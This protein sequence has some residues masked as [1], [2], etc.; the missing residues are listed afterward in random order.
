[1]FSYLHIRS[2]IY[3]FDLT[4]PIS[5]ASGYDKV[6]NYDVEFTRIVIL[7]S[8]LI[9]SSVMGDLTIVFDLLGKLKYQQL[10]S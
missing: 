8:G 6:D 1:M 9:L 10:Y 2:L 5:K 4:L 7:A 3:S